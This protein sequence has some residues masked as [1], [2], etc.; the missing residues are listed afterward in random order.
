MSEPTA[1]KKIVDDG[2]DKGDETDGEFDGDKSTVEF[3]DADDDDDDD[4]V[5]V[6]EDLRGSDYFRSI[7]VTAPHLRITSDVMTKSEF[8]E[9]IGIRTTQIER[10]SAVFTDVGGLCD[11]YNIAVKELY[12]RKSPLFIVR[13]TGMYTQEEWGCNEMGFPPR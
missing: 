13:Q 9:V 10:G 3:D 7:K 2:S 12:D 8:A 1:A 4:K 6:K 11:S 5:D